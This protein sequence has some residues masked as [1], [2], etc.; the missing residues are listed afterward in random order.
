MKMNK[1]LLIETATDV[2]SVA[3]ADGEK[4]IS[5]D[6]ISE[7]RSQAS[8]LAPLIQ[9][10]VA[11]AGMSTNCLDAV[12]VSSG[13]GSYTGL[14]VG[15]STAKGICFGAGI[16]LIGIGT[17]DIIAQGAIRSGILKMPRKALP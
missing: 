4:I 17:L 6:R 1:I 13:P 5:S 7:P 16:P 12:A 3:V 15:V 2:C 11:E 8:G 9:K 10:T 14:R